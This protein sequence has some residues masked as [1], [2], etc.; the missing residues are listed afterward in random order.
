[1]LES[2]TEEKLDNLALEAGE[3]K[4]VCCFIK[5]EWEIVRNKL[6]EVSQ[7]SEAFLQKKGAEGLELNYESR[8]ANFPALWAWFVKGCIFDKGKQ[9]GYLLFI[10]YG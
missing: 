2:T 6:T 7:I 5:I 3:Q 9:Y 4:K 10:D 8:C 1:M